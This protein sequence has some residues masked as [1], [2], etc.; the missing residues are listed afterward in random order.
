MSGIYVWVPQDLKILVKEKAEEQ[1]R[2]VSNYV[3][4]AI[5]EKIERDSH[6]RD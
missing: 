4:L 5:R 3:C 1:Q 6:A 2:S